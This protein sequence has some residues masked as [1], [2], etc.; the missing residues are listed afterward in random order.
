[1]TRAM[2]GFYV[3]AAYN[4]CITLLNQGFP[5]AIGESG[6]LYSLALF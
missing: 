3:V 6:P 1:M 2:L 4:L 5:C